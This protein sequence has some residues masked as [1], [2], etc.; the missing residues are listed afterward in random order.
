MK[1]GF[2]LILMFVLVIC[3]I[4]CHTSNQASSQ[5]T[6]S[7]SVIAMEEDEEPVILFVSGIISYDSLADTY[8]IQIRQQN[9]YAGQ[10]NL[11]HDEE[12]GEPKGLNF[13]QLDSNDKPIICCQMDNPLVQQIEYIDGEE[14]KV[15]TVIRQEAELFLRLQLSPNTKK[16][17]FC[18]KRDTIGTI[19]IN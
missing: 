19:V 12:L 6:E 3:L 1:K 18:H 16:L 11:D 2:C 4:G 13:V 17:Q 15:K 5:S 8:H 9:K 7:I 14:L 10:I